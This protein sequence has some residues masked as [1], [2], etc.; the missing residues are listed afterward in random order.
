[1]TIKKIFEKLSQAE[2][3]QLLQA[4]EQGITQYIDFEDYIIGIN[5]NT[6]FKIIEEG[7]NGWFLGIKN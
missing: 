2:R 1:M 4:F 3:D 7:N 6:D 5:R